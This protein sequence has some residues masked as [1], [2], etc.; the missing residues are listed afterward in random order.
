MQ[1]KR[2]SEILNFNLRLR[3]FRPEAKKSPCTLTKLINDELIRKITCLASTITNNNR[4]RLEQL[5]CALLSKRE[6]LISSMVV[7]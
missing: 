7:V 1:T 4:Y 6:K 2:E 5:H 3:S